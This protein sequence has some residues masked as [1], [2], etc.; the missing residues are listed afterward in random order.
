MLDMT[1]ILA[2]NSVFR[3]EFELFNMSAGLSNELII[4]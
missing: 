2:L 4:G 1:S 3:E